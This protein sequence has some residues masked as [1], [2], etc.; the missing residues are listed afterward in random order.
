MARWRPLQWRL[1]IAAFFS[2]ISRTALVRQRRRTRHEF[3]RWLSSV[4]GHPPSW[5]DSARTLVR[6]IRFR[7]SDNEPST[8]AM[9]AKISRCARYIRYRF[10]YL[11]LSL[12]L[13]FADLWQRGRL[14][15]TRVAFSLAGERDARRERERERER[16]SKLQAPHGMDR[17]DN[18]D[19]LSVT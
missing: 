18:C 14:L 4:D 11:S 9:I 16:E 15:E 10:F 19:F 8:I 13:S 3:I 5:L 6:T 12:S 7:F 2:V 17:K 1:N